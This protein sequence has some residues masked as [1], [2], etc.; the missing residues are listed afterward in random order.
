MKTNYLNYGGRELPAYLG[1]GILDES[2]IRFENDELHANYVFE[3]DGSLVHQV[4]WEKDRCYLITFCHGKAGRKSCYCDLKQALLADCMTWTL[5]QDDCFL[6]LSKEVSA[7]GN[8]YVNHP[9][10]DK[11]ETALS[12]Y[13]AGNLFVFSLPVQVKNQAYHDFLDAVQGS[14]ALRFFRERNGSLLLSDHEQQISLKPIIFAEFI[15]PLARLVSAAK[16]IVAAGVIEKEKALRLMV[17]EAY[18]A[19]T[20]FLQAFPGNEK[21]PFFGIC[22]KETEAG[23]KEALKEMFRL[24]AEGLSFLSKA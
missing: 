23:K 3:S 19:E 10:R 21:Y 7:L 17:N 15:V 6:F 5:Y 11:N 18:A 16:I 20:A 22:F 14:P 2:S 8:I 24:Q 13:P 4:N 12:Y 9:K 1:Y